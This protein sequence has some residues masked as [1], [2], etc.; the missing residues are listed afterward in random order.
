MRGRI[1]TI[2]SAGNPALGQD[3]AAEAAIIVNQVMKMIPALAS[4]QDER[5]AALIG[6]ARKLLA[7]YI[8]EIMRR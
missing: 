6:E 4:T 7:L 1:A 5:A 8:D 2:L 3:E